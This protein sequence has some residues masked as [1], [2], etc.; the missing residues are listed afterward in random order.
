MLQ[1][2]DG[3]IDA[4]FLD[5]F[6][7]SK[8]PDMWNEQVFA[9][10]ARL[11]TN[12]TTLATFTSAGFVRRGLMAAGFAMLRVPGFG[13]KR[14]MLI[15]QYQRADDADTPKKISAPWFARLLNNTNSHP[16]NAM[17]L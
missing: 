7:P 8:N 4:W 2:V 15:G 6:A 9:Q 16:S 10:L 11:A 1:Q 13:R 12:T 5:G 17:P 3:Q 14:E